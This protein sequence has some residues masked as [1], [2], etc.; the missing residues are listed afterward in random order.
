MTKHGTQRAAP[1]TS[2]DRNRAAQVEVAVSAVLG[3]VVAVALSLVASL[4]LALLVGWDFACVVYMTWIWTRILRQDADQTAHR[5]TMTDPDR[6]VTDLLLVC[7]AIASLAAV[8]TVLVQ[9]AQ[10]QGGAEGLRV[11]LSLASVVLSWAMVHT[12]FTLRYAHLYY[13]GPDGGIDFNGSGPPTY[14]D[15][16][17]LAFTIGMTFQVSDT[18]LETQLIRRTALRH[19]LLSYLFGTGILATT[20][21]LVASLSSK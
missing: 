9:A 19:A 13:Q 16:A 15:F 14:H 1:D 10:M 2:Q 17:Y 5:A 18:A 8:G 12:V 20:I 4:S 7:A 11:G 3:V 6:T 21:N